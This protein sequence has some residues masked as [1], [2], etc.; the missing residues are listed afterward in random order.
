M[1]ACIHRIKL[2]FAG[3]LWYDQ[4]F[5]QV[6]P[7]VGDMSDLSGSVGVSLQPMLAWYSLHI[8]LY[9]NYVF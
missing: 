9:G 8:R 6:T 7:H 3:L 2:L 5:V 4:S 1:D